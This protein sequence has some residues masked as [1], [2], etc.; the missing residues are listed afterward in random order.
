MKNLGY[1]PFPNNKLVEPKRSGPKCIWFRC[2][3]LETKLVHTLEEIYIN[4]VFEH[5][6]LKLVNYVKV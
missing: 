5:I 2:S 1:F 6:I 4:L 3:L